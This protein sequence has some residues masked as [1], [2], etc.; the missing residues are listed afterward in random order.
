LLEVRHASI[1]QPHCNS[2]EGIEVMG[3]SG[4]LFGLA[5]AVLF[6]STLVLAPRGDPGARH[7]V[8]S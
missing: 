1:N 4:L 5:F 8:L 2:G 3:D 6:A 7:C